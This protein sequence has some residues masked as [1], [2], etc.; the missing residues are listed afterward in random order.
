MKTS[1]NRRNAG[2]HKGKR[3]SRNGKYLGTPWWLRA[4][5]DETYV[6]VMYGLTE[7]IV[8]IFAFPIHQLSKAMPLKAFVALKTITA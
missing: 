8:F 2:L 7:F 6:R 3:S 5:S 1:I 4:F